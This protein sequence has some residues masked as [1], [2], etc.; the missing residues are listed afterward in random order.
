MS[1]T[2]NE[3]KIEEKKQ[4][5]KQIEDKIEKVKYQYAYSLLEH[6]RLNVLIKICKRNKTQNEEAI[7]DLVQ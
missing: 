6:E 3:K 2:K 5:I 4:K 1:Q 7:P